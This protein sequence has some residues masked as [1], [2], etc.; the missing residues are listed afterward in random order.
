MNYSLLFSPTDIY[1][2]R[3][4][5]RFFL[6]S[7]LFGTLAVLIFTNNAF[8]QT[9]IWR[10]VITNPEG[11]KGFINDE[12]KTL[13]NGN[14]NVW[15]KVVWADG[16]SV[17]AFAEYDCR[18]K[19]RITRQVTYYNR[20]QTIIDTKKRQSDL[21]EWRNIIPGTGGDS[22]YRRVCLS[23]EPVKWAQIIV[24]QV[25]MRSLPDE[26]A[27]VLRIAE[28]GEKFQFVPDT[29]FRGWFNVVDAVTQQDYWLPGNT[30]KIVEAAETKQK[31]ARKE[32]APQP[33]VKPKS[34]A[35]QRK[36]RRN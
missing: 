13:P 4:R 19:R 8:A 32:K 10:Y 7:I 26:S 6:A 17:I 31:A 24:P 9:A 23:P 22:N 16:S 28:E 25:K 1:F 15:E 5:Q 30:F 3:S 27:A 14:K 21:I 29:R 12:M 2:L 35:K 20:D 18:N 34:K 36:H 11:T 33:P